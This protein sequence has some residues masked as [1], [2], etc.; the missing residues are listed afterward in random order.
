MVNKKQKREIVV[1]VVDDDED[2]LEA[3]EKKHTQDIRE[4]RER[5][6]IDA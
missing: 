1:V 6:W 5:M 2:D 4:K 3:R